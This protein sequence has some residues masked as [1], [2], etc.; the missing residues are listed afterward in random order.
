VFINKAKGVCALKIESKG[1]PA[2]SSRIWLGKNAL[3]PIVILCNKLISKYSKNHKKPNWNT[4]VN[5]GKIEGGVSS[6]QVCPEAYVILDFRFPETT[7]AEKILSEV[8]KLAQSI[9]H[10]LNVSLY[11]SG[12][13]TYVDEKNNR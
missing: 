5:I 3:E 10:G 7:S 11:A 13:P 9:D 1:K 4:T 6:N 2:H 8:K 12:Q